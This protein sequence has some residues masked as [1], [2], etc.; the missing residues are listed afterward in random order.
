MSRFL[1]VVPPLI[2]H[3]NPARSVA[4][5]LQADGHQVAWTGS[6]MTLRPMLGPDATIYKT[7]T[8]IHRAQADQGL[9]S[10]KSLWEQFIVPY[11]RFILPAVD[12]AIGDFEPDVVVCDQHTPA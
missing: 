5:Q 7:G 1:F 2:G 6:L 8:R 12:R 4:A 9:A 10:I 3:V 11:T